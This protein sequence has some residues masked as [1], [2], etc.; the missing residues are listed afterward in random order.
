MFANAPQVLFNVFFHAVR[1][2]FQV[3]Y[4]FGVKAGNRVRFDVLYGR[5]GQ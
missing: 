1:D 5:D 3:I 4:C 2:C